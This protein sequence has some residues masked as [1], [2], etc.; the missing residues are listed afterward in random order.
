M[1]KILVAEDDEDILYILDRVLSEAGYAV[2]PLTTGQP[3]VSKT[4]GWPDL[5]ILD[6]DIPIVNG[7][8]V[9]KFLRLKEETKHIP[10]IMISAF[11]YLKERAEEA[12]VD[13]FIQKPFELKK[14]LAVVNKYVNSKPE[15]DPVE[16]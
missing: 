3:I 8:A 15:P 5:F 11:H 10:I 7:I 14:L 16:S 9:S 12:G 13:E 1:K 6:K 2:E 4:T